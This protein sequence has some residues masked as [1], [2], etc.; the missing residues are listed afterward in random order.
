MRISVFVLI[1]L[2]LISAI[3][4][5]TLYGDIYDA[6]SLHKIANV[7]VKLDGPTNMQFMASD[8]YSVDVS[9]GAYMITA[10][11]F[12]SGS[13][14]YI[15]QDNVLVNQ[16]TIHYDLVLLPYDL[17]RLTPERNATVATVAPPSPINT[18][19]LNQGQEP[20]PENQSVN[21]EYAILLVIVILAIGVGLYYMNRKKKSEGPKRIE[22]KIETVT[23]PQP[24]TTEI[25]YVPDKEAREVM[26]IIKENDGHMYQKEVRD[27]LNWSEAKMSVTIAELEREGK[28]KRFKKGRD[29]LLKLIE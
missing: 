24:A 2:V 26:K 17:Y 27:I 9:N 10:T 20:K 22:E 15:T 12:K 18:T 25:G 11:H 7:L 21:S 13:I 1:S 29:N 14:D 3:F 6:D 5:A 23:P 16:S 8:N 19:V 28:V 4:A